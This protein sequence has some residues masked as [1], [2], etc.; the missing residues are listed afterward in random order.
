MTGTP[1]SP[2][3][4]P[5]TPASPRLLR[6]FPV[7]GT[8][9][10]EVLPA[11]E[12]PIRTLGLR[13]LFAALPGQAQIRPGDTT[14]TPLT[15]WVNKYS[16]LCFSPHDLGGHVLPGQPRTPPQIRQGLLGRLTGRGGTS[17]A[18]EPLRGVLIP[19][20]TLMLAVSRD[21]TDQRPLRDQPD[22]WLLAQ[23]VPG[24]LWTL[25]RLNKQDY[26]LPLLHQAQ[27]LDCHPPQG[28]PLGWP[29]PAWSHL[30]PEALS[31]GDRTHLIERGW[32]LAA[33]VVTS[34][35][36]AAYLVFFLFH[37]VGADAGVPGV[38]SSALLLL[39]LL[40]C[41][42]PVLNVFTLTR[43]QIA[44]RTPKALRR[45]VQAALAHPLPVPQP[46]ALPGE[47]GAQ[48]QALMDEARNDRDQT[49]ARLARQ[50]TAARQE[51]PMPDRDLDAA[52]ERQLLSVA[53]VMKASTERHLERTG[54][55]VNQEAEEET[56]RRARQEF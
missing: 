38:L 39:A 5:D 26:W 34:A 3:P 25:H 29:H 44:T 31:T 30:T 8:L 32:V 19:A 33:S 53:G 11:L 54:Q 28:V 21:A 27:L 7:L 6:H 45:T 41:A 24:E 15:D 56:R 2:V 9:P 10:P 36:L 43:D 12:A 48:V 14:S 20:G 1:D 46:V 35:S 18:P 22:R 47:L 50:S 37:Q 17:P 16:E 42:V 23:P 55:Q 52:L 40:L 51:A 4:T 49:L 13:A